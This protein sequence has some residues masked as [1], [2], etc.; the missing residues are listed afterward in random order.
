MEI[1]I[2]IQVERWPIGRLIPRITNPRTHTPEQV[3]KIAA[4]VA[5]FGFNRPILSTRKLASSP[6]TADCSLPGSSSCMK[7]RQSF[8]NTSARRRATSLLPKTWERCR[9]PASGWALHAVCAAQSNRRDR[10]YPKIHRPPHP[11]ERAAL[12]RVWARNWNFSF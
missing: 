2:D 1:R 9:M 6:A 11:V 7:S 10:G 3:A 8:L 4:S 5:E 12:L